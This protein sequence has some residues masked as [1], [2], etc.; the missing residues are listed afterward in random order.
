MNSFVD[1][2]SGAVEHCQ[3]MESQFPDLASFYSNM[4]S[5]LQQKLWHQL[6]LVL[7]DVLDQPSTLRAYSGSDDSGSSLKN[8]YVALYRK[9]VE[10]VAGKLNLLALGRIAAAVAM[11]SLRQGGTIPESRALLEEALTKMEAG[12]PHAS[13]AVLFLESKLGLLTIQEKSA[14]A[15]PT[16]EDLAS[17]QAVIQQNAPLLKQLLPDS[18]EA[19]VVHASHYE[20]TMSYHKLIGPPESFFDQAIHYL[21][22]YTPTDDNKATSHALAVDLC[23]A[24]LTGDGVF[25]LGQIVTN[26]IL[27]VLDGTPEHWLMELLHACA[28]GDVTAFTTLCTQTYSAQIASQPALVNMGRQMQEKMT[29]LAFLHMVFERP[30]SQ[31]TLLFADIATHLQI[32]LEQVEWV[33]MRAFS[34]KLME[35]TMDQVEQSVQITWVLPRTLSKDQMADL[36]SRFGDWAQKVSAAQGYMQE[37]ATLVA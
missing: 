35:G 33:I 17:V 19:K 31:R 9:V 37:N 3:D 23:L 13:S 15:S 30:A 26:P 20:M 29:L 6:T 28:D 21:N 8:T 18:P 7:L 1:Q 11:G 12:K 14:A 34:V 24:A 4:S 36:A 22:F 32:P 16:K 10:P 27:Q 25:N 5:H 2:T